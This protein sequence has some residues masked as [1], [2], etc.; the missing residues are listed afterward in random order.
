[1]NDQDSLFNDELNFVDAVDLS[2]VFPEVM[3]GIYFLFKDGGPH[4]FSQCTIEV[5]PIYRQNIWPFI[6]RVKTK[7]KGKSSGILFGSISKS[8]LSYVWHRLYHANLTRI[9]KTYRSTTKEE[10]LVMP[11]EIEFSMHRI[12]ASAFIPNDDPEK[13]IWVDHINGNRV[14]YRVENLRWVTPEGNAKGTPGGK[15]DPN[16]IYELM[17][18][19]KWFS[20]DANNLLETQKDKYFNGLQDSTQLNLWEQQ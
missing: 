7:F 20:G 19:T 6:Y 13:K 14:D 16:E 18:K 11:K 3:P 12:V 1:M 9:K 10:T 2:T 15:N 4:Y 8:K 17:S 5:D